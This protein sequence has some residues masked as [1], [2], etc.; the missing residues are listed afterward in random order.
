MQHIE[1]NHIYSTQHQDYERFGWDIISSIY[2]FASKPRF[3][4]A[5]ASIIQHIGA[6]RT[7]FTKPGALFDVFNMFG[8]HV[9]T[10]EGAEW[11]RHRKLTSRAFTE[12]NM[13]M[14]WN[15]STRIVNEMFDSD[16]AHRGDV[17]AIDDIINSTTQAS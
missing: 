11:V 10:A 9:L 15:Q 4:I 5:D 14:V 13:Q 2:W 17:V 16:W 8:K 6:S 12:P 1:D 3:F 7:L